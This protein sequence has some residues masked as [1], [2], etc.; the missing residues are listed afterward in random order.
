M[1]Y[2]S[3]LFLFKMCSEAA[4]LKKCM[5]GEGWGWGGFWWRA[6]TISH[7]VMMLFLLR[8]L[9][10]QQILETLNTFALTA[11]FN[12]INLHYNRLQTK[13]FENSCCQPSEIILKGHSTDFSHEDQLAHL[14]V[15]CKVFCLCQVWGNNPNGVISM[16]SGLFWLM[17]R[18]LFFFFKKTRGACS[19]KDVGV[20]QAARI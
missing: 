7:E 2:K 5:E 12:R 6:V 17:L 9:S 11:I 20:H 3:L 14:Q 18:E 16:S 10:N 4:Y 19:V 13:M 15:F 8:H 1:S